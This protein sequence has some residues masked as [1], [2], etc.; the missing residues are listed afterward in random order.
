ME[1]AVEKLE[2]VILDRE[3]DKQFKEQV[4]MDEV[5]K[6]YESGGEEEAHVS[7]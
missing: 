4:M 6:E 1:D 2:D 5:G 7:E 3:H